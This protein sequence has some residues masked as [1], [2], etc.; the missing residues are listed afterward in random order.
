M[1]NQTVFASQSWRVCGF[2]SGFV[3]YVLSAAFLRVDR[4]GWQVNGGGEGPGGGRQ[5]NSA[6]CSIL[7]D[8]QV[9]GEP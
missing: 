2:G 3:F 5:G 4:S 1:I 8:G 7:G 9:R 6:R